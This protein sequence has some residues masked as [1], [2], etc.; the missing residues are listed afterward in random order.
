MSLENKYCVKL[1][2]GTLS[3]GKI[4][5]KFEGNDNLYICKVI[6]VETFEEMSHTVLTTLNDFVTG[7]YAFF[8]N[9]ADMVDFIVETN[10][11]LAE[12]KA[13]YEES[14]KENKEG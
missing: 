4:I 13:K 12:E 14:L 2:V 9:H 10:V 7:G 6:D 8:D 11:K 5:E 1:F 3:A